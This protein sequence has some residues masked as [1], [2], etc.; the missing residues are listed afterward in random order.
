MKEITTISGDRH[1]LFRITSWGREGLEKHLFRRYP[2][3]EWGTFFRFGFSRARWGLA[4]SFVDAL[5]PEPGD[6]D[7]QSSITTFNA[8]YTLRA[9]RAAECRDLAVGVVHSHPEGFRTIPSPL[10]DDMDMYFANEMASYSGGAPYCSLIFQ[11]NAAGRFTFTGRVRDGDTWLPVRDLL[12]VGHVLGRDRAEDHAPDNGPVGEEESTTARLTSLFGATAQRRLSDS[13]VGVIG[14]SGT[15]SPATLVLARAGVGRFVLVDPERVSRSNLERLHG[16]VYDDMNSSPP[17]F[18][19]EVMERM[20]RA[21]NPAAEITPIR[22]NVLSNEALGELLRCDLLLGCVDTQHARVWLSDIAKHYLLPAIDVGV[23]MEG[24]NGKV[25]TQVAELTQYGPHFPCAFCGERI[26]S[27]TLASELMDDDERGARMSAAHGAH[28]KGEDG[29]HYWRGDAPQIHTVGYLTTMVGSLA[30]GY[31]E[32]WLTGAFE[33]PHSSMQF[34]IGQSG[35]G[36][37]AT[38]RHQR[39]Q[40]S[41]NRHRGWGDQAR[42]FRNIAPPAHWCV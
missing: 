27:D 4:L 41:C 42:S 22:T 31:A 1:C 20:I 8:G 10:D 7:R 24:A 23:L 18:K 39:A 3:H 9:F 13:T 12:S 21:I 11:R 40:C 19:V 33:M 26:E 37:V 25:L 5:L 6:L 32:G 35:F 2:D 16:S 29:R 34:D 28:A 15:G 17:P 38:P 36:L 30:S 14:C